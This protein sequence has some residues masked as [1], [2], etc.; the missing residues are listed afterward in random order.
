MYT[1]KYNLLT[2]YSKYF[3]HQI[4]KELDSASLHTFSIVRKDD[5]DRLRFAK[6]FNEAAEEER[7]VDIN[8]FNLDERMKRGIG[9]LLG[10][11]ICDTLCLPT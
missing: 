4:W 2:D 10:L 1:S 11:A 6:M 5:E 8:V 3:N 7:V 9:C